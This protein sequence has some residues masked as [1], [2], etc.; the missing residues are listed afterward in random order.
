MVGPVTPNSL[1]ICSTVWARFFVWSLFLVHFACQFELAGSEFWFLSAGA[2]ACPGC[3]ESV[4]GAFGHQCVFE[5]GEGSDDLEEHAAD[6][7]VPLS[8]SSSLSRGIPRIF[9]PIRKHA[10]VVR[11]GVF[12]ADHLGLGGRGGWVQ[13]A[14]N[15]V[16]GVS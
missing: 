2:S 1:A 16:T 8:G 12:D 6:G 7:G 15:S 5:F 14:A 9:A 13:A 10:K 4:A 11:V 3:G